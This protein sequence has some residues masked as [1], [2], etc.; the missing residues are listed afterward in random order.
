MTDDDSVHDR[1][2]SMASCFISFLALSALFFG[3]AGRVFG[4][5]V[6]FLRVERAFPEANERRRDKRTLPMGAEV[7]E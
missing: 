7:V 1:R 3:C 6:R 2:F 5:R 4:L